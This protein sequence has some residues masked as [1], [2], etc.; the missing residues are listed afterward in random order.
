MVDPG[1][2]SKLTV[3]FFVVALDVKQ[4]MQPSGADILRSPASYLSAGHVF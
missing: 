4:M 3:T 1:T 2:S